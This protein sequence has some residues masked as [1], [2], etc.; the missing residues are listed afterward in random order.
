MYF[1]YSF[2]LYTWLLYSTVPNV[3]EWTQ[4]AK[5]LII[6]EDYVSDSIKGYQQIQNFK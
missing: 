4:R 2:Y 5:M 6:Y 3:L 1:F